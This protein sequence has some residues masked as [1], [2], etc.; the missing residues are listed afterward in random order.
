MPRVV[1][2]TVKDYLDEEE[3]L[4]GYKVQDLRAREINE[5]YT[6][7]AKLL[8]CQSRNIAFAYNATDAY[9]KAISSIAF[10]E[11]DVIL[12]TDDDYVSNYIAFISLIK[13]FGIQVIRARN[14]ENGDLDLEHFEEQIKKYNPRLVAVTHIPTNSG[15]IQDVIGVGELCEK[16]DVLYLL[17]ACQSV[18]QIPVDVQQIGCDFLSVTGRKFMRGPRG[19]GILYASD[20][21]LEEGYGPLFTDAGGASWEDTLEYK[22]HKE[23]KRF[24]LW[25]N[26]YALV[27]GLKEAVKYAN[28]VGMENIFK[29]NQ[30]LL[31]QLREGLQ[32]IPGVKIF[33]KGSRK[34]NI[35]T[36]RKG[37]LT[38]EAIASKME[39]ANIFYSISGINY[40]LIDY[41]KK[42][43]D[44]TVRLSPHYFNT[45]TEISRV[46]EVI[47]Q[48]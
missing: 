5:F 47:K 31:K 43:V 33:D 39:A 12:T 14:L 34:A 19:T 6:E 16:Y 44:W 28:E 13:R 15:M 35:L 10:S 21:M 37:N 1:V 8:N 2:E 26:S 11:G 24:Q 45:E 40:A 36:F 27:V 7:S 38:Q 17:D 42:G 20:K 46:L 29:Y 4:G 22:L 25:E 23:A 30:S 18:G 48:F 32:E 9:A 41:R 3:R